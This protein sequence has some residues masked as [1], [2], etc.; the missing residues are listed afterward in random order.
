MKDTPE[1]NSPMELMNY[2]AMRKGNGL[3]TNIG[4]QEDR[5]L[6]GGDYHPE[7]KA[8]LEGREVVQTPQRLMVVPEAAP[9]PQSIPEIH[10]DEQWVPT[11]NVV[12]LDEG[13][14]NLNGMN[15]ALSPKAQAAIRKIL[16]A[17][18]IEALKPRR[19]RRAA[20]A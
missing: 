16:V 2:V 14:A 15:L 5:S 3:S 11:Q 6:E 13:T 7:M 4:Y 12:H 1:F 17:A 20:P 8:I 9:E 10:V 18:A 19:K